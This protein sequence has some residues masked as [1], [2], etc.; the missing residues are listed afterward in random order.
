MVSRVCPG[1]HVDA[2]GQRR[3][4]AYRFTAAFEKGAHCNV[5]LLDGKRHGYEQ[6]AARGD[7]RP[8]SFG[9]GV[10]SLGIAGHVLRVRRRS[11][12]GTGRKEGGG[13]GER[14]A[15]VEL[16]PGCLDEVQS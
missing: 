7:K 15:V 6:A 3:G 8:D 13:E 10:L 14:G 2:S 12:R 9:C 5:Q 11:L 16:R 1:R 4:S